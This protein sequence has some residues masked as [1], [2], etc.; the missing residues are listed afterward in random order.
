ME[1]RVYNELSGVTNK[2]K[3]PLYNVVLLDESI[4]MTETS[5][6]ILWFRAGQMQ[7]QKEGLPTWGKFPMNLMRPKKSKQKQQGI[8]EAYSH[9]P[10]CP[11]LHQPRPPR[12]RLTSCWLTSSPPHARRNSV[13]GDLVTG[14]HLT[15]YV[16]GMEGRREWVLPHNP[17]PGPAIRWLTSRSDPIKT[18]HRWAHRIPIKARWDSWS[19]GPM[20]PPV[21][22]SR[23][24]ASLSTH[25]R[26][27]AMAFVQESQS[28]ATTFH[29]VKRATK[30]WQSSSLRIQLHSRP[31]SDWG[32]S[33]HF[34]LEAS[35]RASR[36]LWACSAGSSCSYGVDPIRKDCRRD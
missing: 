6:P 27:S 18:S 21:H 8:K 17:Y 26:C 10:G 7:L 4:W 3:S 28:T 35:S 25:P 9:G 20:F 11:R 22:P 5:Y 29:S 16:P 34:P 33:A 24:L 23:I 13:G 30:P 1:G 31:Y 36:E 14:G 12:A 15:N 32:H 19:E 2:L